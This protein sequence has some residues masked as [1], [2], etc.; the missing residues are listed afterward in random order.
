MQTVQIPP[1]SVKIVYPQTK[2]QQEQTVNKNKVFCTGSDE[3]SKHPKV[4]ISLKKNQG[5]CPYCGTN[6]KI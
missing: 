6:F 4:Y 2:I 5:K 3:N 1:A